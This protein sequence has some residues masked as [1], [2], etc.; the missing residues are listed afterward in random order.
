MAAIFAIS[1]SCGEVMV[2]GTVETAKG[3]VI[4]ISLAT[5]WSFV[6]SNNNKDCGADVIFKCPKCTKGT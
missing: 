4:T 6:T 1:C 5:G 3:A 2:P